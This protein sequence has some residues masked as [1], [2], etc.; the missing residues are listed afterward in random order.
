MKKVRST[1]NFFFSM[2]D[3]KTTKKRMKSKAKRYN[4]EG[5]KIVLRNMDFKFGMS[6]P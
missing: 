3:A 2:I 6:Q 1:P 5:S 4:L